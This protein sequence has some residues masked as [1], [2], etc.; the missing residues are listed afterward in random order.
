MK[1]VLYISPDGNTFHDDVVWNCI[2]KPGYSDEVLEEMRRRKRL[3]PAF[4]FKMVRVD[5]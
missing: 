3:F 4:R 1:Y 5:V 2:G